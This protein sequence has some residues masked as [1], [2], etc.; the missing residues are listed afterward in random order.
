MFDLSSRKPTS[1]VFQ[2]C[3]AKASRLQRE[4]EKVKPGD[5]VS[6]RVYTGAG[7][8][9]DV[10]LT[11]VPMSDLPRRRTTIFGGSALPLRAPAAPGRVEFRR[12]LEEQLD[13]VAPRIQGRVTI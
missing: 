4:M 6:L 1:S 10:R 13:R 9:R 7:R 12:L 8:F 3:R 11:T 5:D 2:S